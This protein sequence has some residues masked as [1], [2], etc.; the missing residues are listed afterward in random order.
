MGPFCQNLAD[1][2]SDFC[3]SCSMLL[4]K[5]MQMNETRS[6]EQIYAL[7]FVARAISARDLRID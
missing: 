3:R 6:I 1:E 2:A 4:Q 5:H 7:H